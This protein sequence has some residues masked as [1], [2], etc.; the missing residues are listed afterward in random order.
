M[1]KARQGF[2]KI[3]VCNTVSG[4]DGNRRDLEKKKYGMKRKGSRRVFDNRRHLEKNR[5]GIR[6]TEAQRR[7]KDE[8]SL[9]KKKKVDSRKSSVLHVFDFSV[10]VLEVRTN[11]H[12]SS[13]LS[14]LSLNFWPLF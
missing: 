10:F 14:W 6:M 7:D 3:R 9:R 2:Y 13:F 12:E 4:A 8:K 1:R 11:L 5:R